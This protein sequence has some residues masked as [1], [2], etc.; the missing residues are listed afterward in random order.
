MSRFV[1]ILFFSTSILFSSLS[2][3]EVYKNTGGGMW[4]KLK[5]TMG[6]IEEFTKSNSDFFSTKEGKKS[7]RDIEGVL[8]NMQTYWKKGIKAKSADKAG[9]LIDDLVADWKKE[10]K[11]TCKLI[12]KQT[13]KEGEGC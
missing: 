13:G 3:A 12:E 11:E 7:L 1:T 6:Q 9:D 5:S 2:F 10:K 4:T 8:D